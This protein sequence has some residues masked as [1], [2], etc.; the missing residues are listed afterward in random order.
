MNPIKLLLRHFSWISTLGEVLGESLRARALKL[1]ALTIVEAAL[2]LL[3]IGSVVPLLA[4]A[5]NPESELARSIV[6][7]LESFAGPLGTG[8][9][10][11]II[12]A[13]IAVM[14]TVRA[15]VKL[16]S[17]IQRASFNAD[18]RVH[19]AQGLMTIYSREP[20][21]RQLRADP[22]RRLTL[23]TGDAANIASLAGD[24]IAVVGAGMTVLAMALMMFIVDWRVTAVAMIVGAGISGAA[25]L[26]MSSRL[27][28]LG[29]HVKEARF[30][31]TALAARLLHGLSETSI[32]DRDEK[33]RSIFHEEAHKMG[34]SLRKSGLLRK[35]PEIGAEW[36]LGVAVVIG[37]WVLATF[38]NFAAVLPLAVAFA[39]ATLRLGPAAMS[40]VSSAALLRFQLGSL[41]EV[42]R[43]LCVRPA[44]IKFRARETGNEL[45]FRKFI[46]FSQVSFR[47]LRATSPALTDVDVTIPQGALLAVCGPS[48][49]GKSTFI[50]LLMGL[51]VPASGELRVDG[52]SI[53]GREGD[54]QRLIALVPQEPFFWNASIRDNLLFGRDMPDAEAHIWAALETAHVADFVRSLPE[55]LETRLGERGLRVSGGQ[56]QRLAIARALIGEP[57]LLVLDEPTSALDQ[58][59]AQAIDEALV[60]LKGRKT[61]V[62]VAHRAASVARCDEVV[63]FEAGR[64]AGSGSFQSLSDTNPG[65]GKTLGLTHFAPAYLD[66]PT[67]AA[68]G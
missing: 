38:A 50:N 57:E 35:L 37:I 24:S 34:E 33:V 48:G 13:G 11:G 10:L 62:I 5:A 68:R 20:Y 39:V 54:W 15:V 6:S 29:Y 21:E 60:D 43:D 4:L 59:I 16:Y 47:Y 3:S 9:A 31:M 45:T 67:R 65:F 28:E 22:N 23:I 19:V 32:Y 42:H 58:E 44:G 2:D 49:S 36:L 12:A 66:A 25:Y 61:V 51:L 56:R 17:A 63:Y 18:V 14:L 53:A 41:S 30:Q 7:T 27:R 52:V 55:K 1:T 8:Q 26:G 46:T 40:A 64:V